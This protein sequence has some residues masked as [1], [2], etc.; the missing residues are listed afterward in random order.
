MKYFNKKLIVISSVVVAS[1]SS[2]YVGIWLVIATHVK[3]TLSKSLAH[4]HATPSN[5]I[6]I[7]NFPFIPKIHI[8]SLQI[9]SSSLNILIPSLLLKY[10]LLSNTL[11][12]LGS[13]NTT[14]KFENLMRITN[15][16]QPNIS[17]CS[18]NKSKLLVKPSKHLLFLLLDNKNEKKAYFTSMIYEDNGIT[19][20]DNAITNKNLLH[21]ETDEHKSL[22]N[23]LTILQYKINASA[24][25]NAD[26]NIN[27]KDAI[28]TLSMSDTEF[29]EI[30]TII[31]NIMLAFKNSLISIYGKLSFPLSL[32]SK[33]N[34][35]KLT[36]EMSSYK[37][38][39][40]QL[41]EI[42]H[43]KSHYKDKIVD[44]LQDYIYVISEKK[45]NGNII[46]SINEVTNPF[47]IFIGKVP[48]EE[49]IKKI[50]TIINTMDSR[51]NKK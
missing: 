24:T 29:K 14:L 48:Y 37:G 41:V 46:L 2:L 47:N 43:A 12:F 45:D 16:N 28:V 20:N 3:A 10:H 50:Q 6:H 33:I 11:E 31:D 22:D 34:N 49:F 15:N 38:I 1:I 27:I 36:I 4:I 32:D 42:F 40:K 26:I 18:L 35:E 8:S 9:N 39:I 30:S 19:C 23:L 21:I 13:D 51:E 5:D 7:T 17:I 25:D 44:A